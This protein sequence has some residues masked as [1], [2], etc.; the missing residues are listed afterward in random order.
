MVRNQINLQRTIA[1]LVVLLLSFHLSFTSKYFLFDPRV[2][3]EVNTS[4][5]LYG[6]LQEVKSI[7]SKLS[8]NEQS[9]GKLSDAN[10]EKIELINGRVRNVIEALRPH[11]DIENMATRVI[12]DRCGVSNEVL[13]DEIDTIG[14]IRQCQA[15]VN[16]MIENIM[17]I[18]INK[19]KALEKDITDTHK[20]LEQLEKQIETEK[21]TDKE[22]LQE[23]ANTLREV[24]ESKIDPT[25]LVIPVNDQDDPP[26]PYIAFLLMSIGIVLILQGSILG[27][28]F[29]LF[30]VTTLSSPADAAS[31]DGEVDVLS[32]PTA[33]VDADDSQK[34]SHAAGY[35]G[36]MHDPAPRQSAMVRLTNGGKRNEAGEESEF[37][38]PNKELFQVISAGGGGDYVV[39]RHQEAE[40]WQ[41]YEFDKS[42]LGNLVAK[43]TDANLE[44]SKNNANIVSFKDLED[45]VVFSAVYNENDKL[46]INFL[47]TLEGQ[48]FVSGITETRDE[49]RFLFTLG[50]V[51]KGR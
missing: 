10:F 49:G 9:T 1:C 44:F 25:L 12:N 50:D 40:I 26:V 7:T 11:V 24:L 5:E 17:N 46:E 22:E 45:P 32:F 39:Y 19:K 31:D 13:R 15:Y 42:G 48:R 21:D 27:V 6:I 18:L 2:F 28:P 51:S 47:V 14:M 23:R 3:A 16:M 29:L 35:A 4:N 8:K 41:V 33:P 43:I 36:P 30:G 37:D 34:P 20:E 38:P